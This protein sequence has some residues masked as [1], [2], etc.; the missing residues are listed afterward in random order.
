M[1]ENNFAHIIIQRRQVDM[2]VTAFLQANFHAFAHIDKTEHL[3]SEQS[4]ALDLKAY[5]ERG[6]KC[7]LQRF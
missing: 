7:A 2:R 1:F 4:L 5:A 6:F 3:W